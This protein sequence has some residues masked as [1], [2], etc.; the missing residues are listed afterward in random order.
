MG[1]TWLLALIVLVAAVPRA[2]L[3][4]ANRFHPDEALYTALARLIVTGRDP[5]LAH[6]PLLVDK[7]PLL[8]YT[9]AA[10][11]SLSWNSEFTARLP[12]LFASLISVALAAR[13]AWNVWRSTAAAAFAA[14][15]M[16][17][18]PFAILF[19]PTAFADPLAVTWLLA[20]WVTVTGPGS[21]AR[22]WALAG[23]LLGLAA[24]TKQSMLAFAPLVIGLGMVRSAGARTRLRDMLSWL[25]WFALG[26]GVVGGL[27]A[28]WDALRGTSFWAAGVAVNNPGRLARS[29]E[30]WTRAHGWLD[31]AHYMAASPVV[32]GAVLALLAALIP[33]ELR[34]RT[35]GSAG[36][37]VLLAMAL[38][39]AA[40][41]WLV[42][43][44]LLD[45]YLLPLVPLLALLS[46]HALA[47]ITQRVAA[48][49]GWPR[50]LAA[51]GPGL[52]IVAALARPAVLAAQSAYPVGGDH[53]AY[54]GIDAAAAYLRTLPP[55]SV[56]YHDSLGWPLAYYLLDA[57]L[58][59]APFGS[60]GGL[61]A[62]L[63]T[64]GCGGVMRTLILPA[65][66]SH[67]EPLAA[68]RAAGCHVAPAFEAVD[69]RG[70]TSFTIYRIGPGG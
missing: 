50:T 36:S 51:W 25:L 57:P 6:T 37:L 54:D 33:L 66:E 42:A 22:R 45:R 17:L 28:G 48:W 16:A 47:L 20:A 4:T 65:W 12:A 59:V 5:L 67:T 63:T 1:R 23:L 46:A 39:Y 69:R 64:F 31:W 40:L 11:L 62:D 56:V 18:S 43:F 61:A 14:L 3:L 10:G 30:V 35:R 8:F 60:P 2:A 49:R 53:G 68:V 27:A 55:G 7:P 32:S 34:E 38:A 13:L 9:L 21:G 41:L 19:A 44:P 15:F 24:A 52:L 26:L 70:K 58:Y 29:T